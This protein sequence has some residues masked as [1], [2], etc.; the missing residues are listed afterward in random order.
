VTARPVES[1]T[2][3]HV[4]M[5]VRPLLAFALHVPDRL[6]CA[7][8]PTFWHPSSCAP[9]SSN[10][11]RNKRHRSGNRFRSTLDSAVEVGCVR[12]A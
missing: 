4:P 7:L 1:G 12:V 10:A 9:D 11:P 3:V 8:P 5:S 6:A 2:A